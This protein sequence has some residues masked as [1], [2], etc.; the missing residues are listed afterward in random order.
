M[1]DKNES[2]RING[3]ILLGR[4]VHFHDDAD[5]INIFHNVAKTY[6]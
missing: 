2:D 6:I 1:M 5:K 3:K 4:C